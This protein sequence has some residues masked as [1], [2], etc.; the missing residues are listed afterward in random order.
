MSVTKAN[1]ISAAIIS[2]VGS[3]LPF[4]VL[5]GA[6]DWG[7]DTISAAVLVV[8]QVVTLG[9]LIFASTPA[10]NTPAP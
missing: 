5:V 1:A 3:T 9:G 8:T 4:L 7:A 2:L 6:L 10:S